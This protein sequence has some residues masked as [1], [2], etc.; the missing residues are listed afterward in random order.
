MISLRRA[1]EK[2]DLNG[3]LDEPRRKVNAGVDGSDS[4][5]LGSG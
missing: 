3:V 1:P 4:K 5:V 2:E